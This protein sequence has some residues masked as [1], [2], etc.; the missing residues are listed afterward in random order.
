MDRGPLQVFSRFYVHHTKSKV[1]LT[2]GTKDRSA[3]RVAKFNRLEVGLDVEVDQA[4]YTYDEIVSLL[5]QLHDGNMQ[6]GGLQLVCKVR[7]CQGDKPCTH[8]VRTRIK[9]CNG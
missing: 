3:W 6:H 9:A 5:K 2:T 8:G 4:E 1:Y 7:L